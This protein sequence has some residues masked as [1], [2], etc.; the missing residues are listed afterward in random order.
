MLISGFRFFVSKSIWILALM[1]FNVMADALENDAQLVE[2]GRRIYQDG[3]LISGAGLEGV[4]TGN[5]KVKGAQAACVNCHRRSGMGSV[6]G[7]ILV[8]PITGNYLFNPDKIQVSTMDPRSGKKFNQTHPAY[9]DASLVT[10]IAT[11][12]NNSGRKMNPLMPAF[13]LGQ[14]DMAALTAYLKQLST[15]WSPGIEAQTIHLATVITPDVD[16]ERRQAFLNTLQKAVNQKNGS[17]LT[18]ASKRGRHHMT[19]AA[20]MVLGTERKWFCM[21]GSCKGHQ[22]PGLRN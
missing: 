3:V 18:S 6:E 20:E 13:T 19:S 15:E 17:T 11:G 21:F 8:A 12:M 1:S 7:D 10:A 4:R 22:I 16:T 14:S 9:D 2:Q 5:V